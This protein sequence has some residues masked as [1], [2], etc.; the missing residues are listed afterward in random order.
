MVMLI[1]VEIR[2]FKV[3]IKINHRLKNGWM[4][5][6]YKR[7]NNFRYIIVRNKKLCGGTLL[8][9]KRLSI[10]QTKLSICLWTRMM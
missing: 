3:V 5:I 2:L 6:I 4:R 1:L 9:L 8:L 10:G 7:I